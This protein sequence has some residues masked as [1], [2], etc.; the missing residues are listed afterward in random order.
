MRSRIAR[1]AK[2]GY[3][4]MSPD[5]YLPAGEMGITAVKTRLVHA[6]VRHLLPRSPGWSATATQP[7]PIS[8]ADIMVTW[9]S[10][11]TTVMR[12]LRQWPLQ[13]DPTEVD[14]FLHTWQVTAHMLG[15]ED[16]YIPSSF[17]EADAQAEQVLDPVLAG[18]R[19]GVELAQILLDMASFHDRGPIRRFLHAMTRYVLGDEAVA[20]MELPREPYWDEFVR[21]GWPMFV[22]FRETGLSVRFAP[23]GYWLFDE[24]LRRAT[25]LFL[26]E[27]RP[28]SIEI[29]EGNRE[30][31]E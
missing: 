6:A 28:I 23:A 30:H 12:T 26:A 24:A 2:L 10:L 15:V 27:G 3:D 9:H 16:E 13:L 19:E 22:A 25:L 17:A 21:T 18:T 5:A 8:Q 1:T 29:H 20:M 31:Y 7:K 4:I 14:G 11:P